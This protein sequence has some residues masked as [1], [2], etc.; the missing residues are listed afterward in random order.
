MLSRW[1]T[2]ALKKSMTNLLSLHY[3]SPH[4]LSFQVIIIFV[5]KQSNEKPLYVNVALF[6]K[7][8]CTLSMCTVYEELDSKRS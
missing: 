5:F 8:L 6:Y 2:I 3:D 7:I 4:H 1:I